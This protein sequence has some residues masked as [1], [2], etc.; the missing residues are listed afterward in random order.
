MSDTELE[1]KQKLINE[2]EKEVFGGTDE[3]LSDLEQDEMPRN[4]AQKPQQEQK[5]QN[6]I[7][8][9]KQRRKKKAIQTDDVADET[10]DERKNRKKERKPKK[11][12]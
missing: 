9:A 3:E 12:K 8:E 7:T 4:I 2:L 5:Q 11:T 1:S 6:I 10:I